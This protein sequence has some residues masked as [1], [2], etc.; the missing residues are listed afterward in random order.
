MT[1]ERRDE[2]LGRY[3]GLA[4]HDAG[5]SEGPTLAPGE[6]PAAP[7]VPAAHRIGDYELL[8]EI[9]RG[10]MGVVYKARQV[11]LNRVVALKMVLAGQLASAT[12]VDRF[13]SEAEAAANL[14]HPNVVPIYEV[15]EHEG[16]PYFS[17]KLVE[18]GSLA[19]RRLPLPARES[20]RL[21]AAVARAVHHAHQRGILH[22]DLKPGNIL[23]DDQ[24]RPYVTDFGLARRVEGDGRHTLT[25]AVVGTPGYMA[26]EQA[27]SAKVLT[28]AVDVYGLGAILYELL[29]GRPPFR[30]A[31]PLETVLQ[32]LERE[33]DRLSAHDPA[34]DRDLEVICL[35]CLDKEPQKR[36]GSALALAED[37][38][39]WLAGEAIAA[40]P[41]GRGER[42]WRWCRRKP[43]VTSLT[44]A[45]LL[46][47]VGGFVGMAAL[48]A[49][50]ARQRRAAEANEASALA[51][52]RKALDQ[53]RRADTSYRLARAA[54][55]EQMKLKDDPRLQQGELEEVRKRLLLNQAR[56]YQ[57]FLQLRGDDEF[58]VERALALF[59]L[60]RLSGELGLNDEALRHAALA[61][62]ALRDILA[63]DPADPERRNNLGS[64]LQLRAVCAQGAGRFDD[65]EG[66]CRQAT[67]T[68]D[69][70]AREAPGK[71][72][73]RLNLS[74]C[75][76]TMG[77]I[78][79]CRNRPA[80]AE[81]AFRRGRDL[82]AKLSQEDPDDPQYVWLEAQGHV[83][84]GFA[85]AR[86]ARTKEAEESY[87]KGKELLERLEQ[88]GAGDDGPRK[89][90]ATAHANLGA[91]YQGTGRMDEAGRE[92]QKALELRE[93]LARQHPVSADYLDSLAQSYRALSLYY[94]DMNRLADAEVACRRALEITRKLSEKHGDEAAYRL[95]IGQV[96]SD[97]G[98]LALGLKPGAANAAANFVKL[99]AGKVRTREAMDSYNQ[100][101]ET[102]SGLLRQDPGNDL[103]R[104]SLANAYWGRCL[105]RES[106]LAGADFVAALEDCDQA[107]A[108]TSDRSAQ[109]ALRARGAFTRSMAET[110]QARVTFAARLA[111][112]G[113]YA[114]GSAEVEAALG[115]PSLLWGASLDEASQVLA[116][117]AAAARA[118]TTQPP[119][120]R[121][122]RFE[123]FAGRAV[124]LAMKDRGDRP[125]DSLRRAGHFC[126]LGGY[127][128]DQDRPEAA[129]DFYAHALPLLE[130]ILAARP[131]AADA[132]RFLRNTY[133]GR[134]ETLNKVGR[135][136]D[137]L[138]DCEQALAL[139]EGTGQFDLRVLRA[140]TLSYCGQHEA[141][142]AEALRLAQDDRA[143]AEHLY[144]LARVCAAAARAGGAEAWARGAIDLLGRAVAKG[145][146]DPE[147]LKR[148]ADFAP[149]RSRP[150][151][152]K[153]L[154]EL[155]RQAKATTP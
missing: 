140:R 103:A 118:D 69:L 20:A 129:L 151:F 55:D 13:R 54:L 42:V 89:D 24:Q 88:R 45:L 124:A 22:R 19:G 36:Y 12:E 63:R 17:M 47:L 102:L 135:S 39:R 91:L 60:A 77:A 116:L 146:S 145:Y 120:E 153:L 84:L 64:V 113:R 58:R 112:Q 82:R 67:E 61:E 87:L 117:C 23:L 30:A 86:L 16:R 66:P 62:A 137:A 43:L 35:T 92:L 141:A 15:G 18:G 75:H 34:I 138:K 149:L 9:A 25:G 93:P 73:Y 8:E 144:A 10:G 152:Q 51:N 78:A 1:T 133:W 21:L 147:S 14:D 37:L 128:R 143:T 150:E 123:Q 4:G 3:P 76:M 85:L 80:D 11:S 29:S 104:Q 44:A 26:P 56:F 125:D 148:E 49:H 119:G 97:L 83:N 7:V 72:L 105:A 100:A 132:R 109:E 57:D 139:D 79:I 5:P 32:V 53:Q 121:A 40:R 31:T 6:A 2:L 90:L 98:N 110:P 33:P 59:E 46:A 142:G 38:E 126:D 154:G 27:R 155:E 111:R 107:I 28:T 71:P 99:M 108:L 96:Q 81:A 48:Y 65:A 106:E 68:F 52:E 130:A 50:A 115:K 95:R 74:N 101:I 94:G 134:A 136:Q 70:L 114:E 41:I 122:R 131:G 127:L